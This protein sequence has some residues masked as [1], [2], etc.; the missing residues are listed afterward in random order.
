MPTSAPE[1]PPVAPSPAAPAAS[2]LAIAGSRPAR[3]PI[4]GAADEP[5]HGSW[6]LA[7]LGLAAIGLSLLL[8]RRAEGVK[9]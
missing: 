2:P 7:L 8:R 1:S 5:A 6:P 3:L 4:T 9:P